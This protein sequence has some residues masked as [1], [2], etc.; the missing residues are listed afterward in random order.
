MQTEVEIKARIASLLKIRKELVKI[1]ARRKGS[2]RIVDIYYTPAKGEK[3]YGKNSRLKFR[4][5]Y[6]GGSNKGSLEVHKISSVYEAAE[7]ELPITDVRLVQ[8]MLSELRFI[9]C[10]VVDKVR[11][12]Y[13]YGRLNI[14]LDKVK[15]LGEYMEVEMMNTESKKALI[16][17]KEFYKKIGVSE[18]DLIIGS[19]NV[20]MMMKFNRRK[21]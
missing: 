11:E 6:D 16:A 21:K 4:I 20:E 18:K 15:G 3:Y 19:S 5:R 14:V 17:I 10:V 9:K 2:K 7:Y 12:D 13:K 8:Q 1:G